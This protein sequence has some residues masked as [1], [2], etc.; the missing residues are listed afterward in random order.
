[1]SG[2]GQRL[3]SSIDSSRS[4]RGIHPDLPRHVVVLHVAAITHEVRVLPGKRGLGCPPGW[5]AKGGALCA[6]G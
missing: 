6:C 3:G 2:V 5:S 4:G 1:M